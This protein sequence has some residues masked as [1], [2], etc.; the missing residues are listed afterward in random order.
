MKHPKYYNYLNAEE[1]ED[2]DRIIDI[3][4]ELKKSFQLKGARNPLIKHF[5]LFADKQK[6]K[7]FNSW[8]VSDGS[9]SISLCLIEYESSYHTA[10]QF[11][12]ET[13]TA[14]HKYFFG[15]LG[16]EKDFGRTL[17]RQETL[18]DKISELFVPMEI[19]I[20]G[21]LKFSNKYY[22]LSNDKAK[23]LQSIN[24]ELLD[25]LAD[26]KN[27]ELE[28]NTHN[29]LFLLDKAIDLEQTIRL[30]KTGLQL[31]RILNGKTK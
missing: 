17:L 30:C 21:Y 7:F 24:K 2:W 22:V 6:P 26:Q 20:K 4:S 28:F 3:F 16:S 18:A 31:S 10:D 29:C 25:Y 5:N 13:H 19:D 1:K 11:G 9:E 8:Q 15:Y 27:L 23:F 12:G 14:N